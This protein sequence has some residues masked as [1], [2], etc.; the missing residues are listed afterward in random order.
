MAPP[1]VVL[2]Q[3]NEWWALELSDDAATL[4]PRDA[5]RFTQH[6]RL[7]NLSFDN[8]SVNTS[9]PEK[10]LKVE[11]LLAS[12]MAG[13]CRL[14]TQLTNLLSINFK[15]SSSPGEDLE[16]IVQNRPDLSLV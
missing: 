16:G 7:K 3:C 4:L 11:I 13:R 9:V 8:Y 10:G 12:L 5:W 15:G 14:S 1:R 2:Q 6:L